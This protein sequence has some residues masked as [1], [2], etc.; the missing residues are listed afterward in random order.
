MA[1]SFLVE[2]R[3][4]GYA[5][6]YAKWALARV[7]RK[8]KSLGIRKLSGPKFVSHITLFGGA[9]TSNWRWLASEVERISCKYTLVP[10]KIK[11][12]SNFNNRNKQI[13]YLDVDPSPELEQFRWE[14]AQSLTKISSEYAPWD[15]TQK[16]EFHSTVG[17][18]Q[19][20]S[21][22]KFS[23]LCNYAETQ[24]SLAVFKR[25]R[26]SIFAR[27]FNSIFRPRDYDSGINQ[28][29]LRVTVLKSSR[30]Y[31]EYD[32]LLKKLLSRKEALSRH[33]WRRTI[34][35]L[36]EL[37]NSPPPE[38]V[39][40]IPNKPVWFIG[41]THF[42]HKNILKYAHRPFSNVAAMNSAILNNWNKTV[43]END[44]VYFLGDYT[45]PPSRD[46]DIYYKKLRY[47]T[48]QLTGAKASILGNHD[49][50]GGCIKFD[51]AKI[52]HA[53][54]YRFLLIHDPAKK[55]VWNEWTIHGH[56][57]NN[58]IDNYPFINGEQKTI[59]VSADLINFTP[60]SLSYLLSLDLDSIKR[61]ATIDS[62]P[63]RFTRQN[64]S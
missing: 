30:I 5:R 10:L 31:Y 20:T 51:N 15:N 2:F 37:Q 8:A 25:Q 57:H 46:I 40:L 12:V 34:E 43:G 24:C 60:V 39:I 14:L 18:F 33:W 32:L 23:Q 54:G 47:W 56:T 49:R 26:M 64:K 50:N 19:P 45:G 4:R 53:N 17:I 7:L 63:E 13:I 9:K 1:E 61:M 3:L 35:N 22:D 28:H 44:N 36:R 29:L 6:E 58:E 41:D 38:E 27:L 62:Q 48:K 55:P 21:N 11:G 59:N 42:D 16:Y 52:L